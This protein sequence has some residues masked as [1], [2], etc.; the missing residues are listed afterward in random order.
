MVLNWK[1]THLPFVFILAAEDAKN[2]DEDEGWQ[3]VNLGEQ[4]ST[5]L[6]LAIKLSPPKGI[7]E[8]LELLQTKVLIGY[9]IQ[10][11]S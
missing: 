5:A 8:L 2:M 1:R 11:Q 9:I 6:S 3:F 7:R 10:F 4:V